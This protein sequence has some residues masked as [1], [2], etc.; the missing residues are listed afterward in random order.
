MGLGCKLLNASSTAVLMLASC[1]QS[2]VEMHEAFLSWYLN[3]FL[4][5]LL[6][7][8]KK[9]E[10]ALCISHVE[11]VRPMW[12]RSNKSCC[13][14]C[15]QHGLELEFFLRL[16][17]V[18]GLFHGIIKVPW[19]NCLNKWK[20]CLKH[21]VSLALYFL[22]HHFHNTN[23]FCPTRKIENEKPI[24]I[25]QVTTTSAKFCII[26]IYWVWTIPA[27]RTGKNQK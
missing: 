18:L 5:W 21:Q 11:T 17:L 26:V 3:L 7:D 14:P 19:T 10:A 20:I 9:K 8:G 12:L 24:F 22:S 4:L 2:I 13:S 6:L 1:G 15:F 23:L 16:L 27:N 25:S